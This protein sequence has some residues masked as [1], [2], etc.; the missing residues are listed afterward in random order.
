MAYISEEPL[1][2]I[3]EVCNEQWT[4]A[5][6]RL[7]GTPRSFFDKLWRVPVITLSLTVLGILALAAITCL[8]GGLFLLV[9]PEILYKELRW[10]QQQR[11]KVAY[12]NLQ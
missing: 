4:N 7:D 8:T 5:T 6:K 11:S 10:R 3:H 12:G 1:G 9:I 2:F